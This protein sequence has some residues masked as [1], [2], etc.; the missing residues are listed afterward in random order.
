MSSI[1]PSQIAPTMQPQAII[2]ESGKSKIDDM[3]S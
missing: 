3:T 1:S 2:L